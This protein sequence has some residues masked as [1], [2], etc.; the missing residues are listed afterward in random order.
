MRKLFSDESG[1]A[2]VEYIL[3][4]SMA[5]AV[6]AVIATR[7]RKSIFGLWGVMT[8]EISAACPDCSDPNP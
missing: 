3:A 8:R 2:V 4:V 1:Q 7:F 5:V 6:V